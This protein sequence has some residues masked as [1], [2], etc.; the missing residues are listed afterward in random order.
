[1][2][3]YPSEDVLKAVMT[4]GRHL[5]VDRE[6]NVYR[7]T[8][9]DLIP[10]AKHKRKGYEYV[11]ISSNGTR[12]KLAV[13]RLVATA[14][15]SN[16]DNLPQVNHVD[17][18]PSNNNADNLEWI[19]GSANQM[20]SRYILGNET[21][22]KDTPVMCIETGEVFISTRDAWRKTGINYSHICECA[23]GKRK[24]AGG[25]KWGYAD[26]EDICATSET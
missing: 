2:K 17:G 24:T 13:H 3:T 9:T 26:K 15:H 14:F 12:H 25:F 19:N 22:F 4:S 18:N 6:G 8:E 1:M 5:C 10:L 23:K 11:E 21:G 16:P 7:K 20:H